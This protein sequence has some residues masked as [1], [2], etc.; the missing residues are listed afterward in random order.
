M[1]LKKRGYI[2][3]YEGTGGTI[4]KTREG[5]LINADFRWFISNNS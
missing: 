2:I 5:L 4:W 3:F 1:A